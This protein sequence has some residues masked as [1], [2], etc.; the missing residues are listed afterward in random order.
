MKTKQ[1]ICYIYVGGLGSA[2][3]CLSVCGS[4]SVSSHELRLVDSVG[5][6]VVSLT[7]LALG[8]HKTFCSLPNVW[9]WISTSA[10]LSLWMKPLR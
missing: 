4:V 10:S 2:Q 8:I 7:P 5:L 9:L 6:L 3:A 1:N